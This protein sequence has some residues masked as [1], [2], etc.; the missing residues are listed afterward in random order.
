MSTK[1][2]LPRTK[3]VVRD[4]CLPPFGGDG[5]VPVARGR[6]VGTNLVRLGSE[7]EGTVSL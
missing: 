7:T 1:G 2:L 5:E 3:Y 6:R 4:S